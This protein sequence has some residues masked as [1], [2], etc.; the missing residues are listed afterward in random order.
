[1]KKFF[2]VTAALLSTL[3]F[4]GCSSNKAEEAS[5]KESKSITI[6]AAASLREALNE[7]Q[8]KFEKDKNIKL[9]FNFGSSGALQKQIEE[10]APAD[11]F[12]SA[13]VK[14]MDA[15]QSKNLIEKDSRKNLLGNKLVLIVPEEHKDKIKNVSD[16]VDKDVKISIGEPESVPAGQYAKDS[17]TYLKIWDKLSN[18]IVYAKD[19]KQV[20]AYVEK[21]E[22][23]AGIVYS[24][25]A[26]TLKNSSIVETFE[27]KTHKPI[28][29]PEAIISESKDKA[30]AKLF[31]DY[32]NTDISKQT[33]EKYGFNV[34]VK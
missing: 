8:P 25:D 4:T 9:N 3:Y 7:I 31:I 27:E 23:A 22:V 17:L 5:I 24:S 14:Q 6:C 34:N 2:L 29:Y 18:K 13:G 12:I 28:V 1:M 30:S 21:G 15:L 33:F 19:V 32:L 10:G 20:V 26:T 11:V 16:L